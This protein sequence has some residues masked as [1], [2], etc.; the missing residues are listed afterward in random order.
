MVPR[1]ALHPTKHPRCHHARRKRR[2]KETA[3]RRSA[4]VQ[5]RARV[6]PFI[7][8]HSLFV[9]QMPNIKPFLCP[10]PG[11]I[12]GQATIPHHDGGTREDTHIIPDLRNNPVPRHIAVIDPKGS[13]KIRSSRLGGSAYCQAPKKNVGNSSESD[14]STLVES[15][16][17]K[18]ED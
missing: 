13:C 11:E 7:G 12:R 6:G 3:A 2:S 10:L 14:K 4:S 17:A 18:H 9:Y 5:N 16:R 15:V 8:R 1:G